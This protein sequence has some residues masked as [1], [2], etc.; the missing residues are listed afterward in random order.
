MAECKYVSSES[1]HQNSRFLYLKDIYA[2][3]ILSDER[4]RDYLLK[5][6]S[7]APGL[8]LDPDSFD[9]VSTRLGLSNGLVNNIA[10]IVVKDDHRTIMSRS[11]TTH[12]PITDFKNMCYICEL[13]LRQ[14]KGKTPKVYSKIK[15][16][17]K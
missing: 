7:A 1:L 12:N 6:I 13:F 4:N 2:T 9:V 14:L 16:F 5:V 10:D 8:D 17:C 11:T 15:K 3:K